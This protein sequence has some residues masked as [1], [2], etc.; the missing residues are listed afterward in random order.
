MSYINRNRAR[1]TG[2][3]RTTQAEISNGFWLSFPGRVIGTPYRRGGFGYLRR[4]VRGWNA[5]ARGVPF[6]LLT[7]L[8]TRRCPAEL[9]NEW[10]GVPKHHNLLFRVAVREVESWLLAD[11]AGLSTFLGVGRNLV[12]SDP[13]LLPDPKLTLINLA[14][15]SRQ[16]MIRES[17]VP[18]RGSTAK[19]GRDYN[20]CLCGF[21]RNH[22]DL[23][24][25]MAGSPSLN[26]TVNRLSNFAPVWQ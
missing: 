1:Q 18:P 11:S 14:R 5:A 26:R 2:T 25:A 8:D 13:D 22:W 4:T 6:V 23:D 15:R 3:N 20:G 7:D 17:I 9:I 16:R 10:L 21:V 19:Q 12:P 24:T